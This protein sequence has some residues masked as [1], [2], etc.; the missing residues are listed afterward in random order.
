MR[1][2]PPVLTLLLLLTAC[3]ADPEPATEAV[4]SLEGNWQLE[5]A[6]RDN[7]KTTLLDG[8]YFSFGPAGEFR[9]NLLTNEDQAGRYRLDGEEILTEGVEI[10]LTYTIQALTEDQLILRASYQGYLFDFALRRG[11]GG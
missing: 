3:G 5:S 4:V 10:P 1:I 7:V 8:L 6:R 2:L 11:E 9:T